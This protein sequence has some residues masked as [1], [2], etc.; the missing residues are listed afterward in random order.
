MARHLENDMPPETAADG[1]DTGPAETQ[2]G[3]WSIVPG[4][5]ALVFRTLPPAPPA[6]QAD[7]AWQIREDPDTLTFDRI[8]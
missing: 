1:R 7:H 6:P 4:E 2:A 5:A 8:G 3:A